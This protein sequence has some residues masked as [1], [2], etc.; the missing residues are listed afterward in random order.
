MSYGFQVFWEVGLPRNINRKS[1]SLPKR[2]MIFIF[3]ESENDRYA[4]QELFCALRPDLSFLQVRRMREPLIL[5]RGDR[6]PS[7]RRKTAEMIAALVR[8]GNVVGTVAAVIAHEDCDDVEP[9]HEKLART[10]AMELTAAGIPNPLAAPPAWEIEAWW[11]LFPAALGAT[12]HCWAAVDY[13]DRHVGRIRD[14]KEVLRRDLRPVTPKARNKCPDYVES[15]SIK[16][17]SAIREKDLHHNPRGVS[18]SFALFATKVRDL[19]IPNRRRPG[20]MPQ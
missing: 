2:S 14:A 9:A 19:R 10:I 3:G 4:L 1:R 18:D 12:R 11:M 16:I 20:S 8:A 6:H 13:S 7:T 15:D 5:M 17:A